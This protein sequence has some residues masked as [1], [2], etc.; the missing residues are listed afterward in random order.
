M[1]RALVQIRQRYGGLQDGF[2]FEVETGYS[3]L[4]GPNN[5]GKSSLLQLVFSSLF[6]HPDFGADRIV[7][8][9][10]ERTYA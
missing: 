4:A 9:L 1:A 5:S 3:V 2:S 7:L 6:N 8:L 10:P